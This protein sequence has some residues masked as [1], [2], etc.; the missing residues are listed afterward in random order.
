M[1]PSLTHAPERIRPASKSI[2]FYS[3]VNAR[4]LS[5]I[6]RDRIRS[7]VVLRSA[8]PG[9]ATPA[10]RQRLQHFGVTGIIDLRSSEERQTLPSIASFDGATSHHVPLVVGQWDYS[11]LDD[12]QPVAEFLAKQY[13]DML[14]TAGDRICDALNLVTDNDGVTLIHCTAGKDRTGLIAA[15]LGII[16]GASLT[17]IVQDYETSA[18]DMPALFELLR[19]HGETSNARSKETVVVPS[20]EFATDARRALLFA[21]PALALEV[22]LLRVFPSPH[23][24]FDEIGYSRNSRRHLQAKLTSLVAN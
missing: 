4:D 21:S 2:S 22:A 11:S 16:A 14:N 17:N 7:G 19:A 24:Y 20:L 18:E 12:G 3:I 23:R 1:N 5:A 13:I 15:L 9:L 6:D 10:D 8:V